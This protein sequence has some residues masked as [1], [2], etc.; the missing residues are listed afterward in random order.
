MRVPPDW[1]DRAPGVEMKILSIVS[2]NHGESEQSG[3]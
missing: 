1:K 3:R 2:F